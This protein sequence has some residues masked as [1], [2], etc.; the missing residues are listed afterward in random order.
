VLLAGDTDG[1]AE[2]EC[3]RDRAGHGRAPHVCSGHRVLG[4]VSDAAE[5]DGDSPGEPLHLA[6]VVAGVDDDL[7]AP[8]SGERERRAMNAVDGEGLHRQFGEGA[9]HAVGIHHRQPGL[10]RDDERDH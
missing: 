3:H 10:G 9:P 2:R 1:A 5:A 4:D 7:L 6:V 8:F